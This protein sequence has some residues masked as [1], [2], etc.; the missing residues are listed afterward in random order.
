MVGLPTCWLHPQALRGR[1]PLY[2]AGLKVIKRECLQV[3]GRASYHNEKRGL[4][5]PGMLAHYR[6]DLCDRLEARY[7]LR[8]RDRWKVLD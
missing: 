6:Q 5:V 3:K 2:E 1:P 8:E 4:C 7:G